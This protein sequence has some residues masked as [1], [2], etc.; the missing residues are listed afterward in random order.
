M[1]Q[2]RR[3]RCSQRRLA[4]LASAVT[5]Q[6][7]R[8]E[9]QQYFEDNQSGTLCIPIT[10]NGGQSL[11]LDSGPVEDLTSLPRKSGAEN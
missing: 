10:F 6:K 8:W 5:S 2:L 4:V 1:I 9:L 3:G 11:E 7:P